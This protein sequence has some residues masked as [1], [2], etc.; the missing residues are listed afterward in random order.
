MLRRRSLERKLFLWLGILSVLP[1]LAVLLV[2]F[3]VGARSLRLIGTLGPWSRVA[4]S[5]RALIEQAE[6]APAADSTLLAAAARHRENLSESLMQA[7]RWEFLGERLAASAPLIA[8]TLAVVLVVMALVIS[9]GL[10]HQLARPI[11]ELV[12]WAGLLGRGEAIPG[13]AE[14]ERRELAD[15]QVL[16]N[17][18]RNAANEIEAGR[19]R[20]LEAERTRAWG[21]I[22]R[23]VAH[24]MKNPL[25]PLRLAAHQL[26]RAAATDAALHETAEVIRA[27]TDRLDEL[28]KGFA[29]LGR[30]TPGPAAE[31]DL[32]ELLDGLLET[33]VPATIRHTIDV[34]PGTSRVLG[35]YDALRRAFRNLIRNAVEAIGEA[36]GSG[37]GAIDI[38]VRPVDGTVEIVIADTGTGIPDGLAEAIFEPD[39]SFKANGTGLGL[40]IVRQVTAA[41]GGSVV[42]RNRAP[43][44][45]EFVIRLP[46]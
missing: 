15:V 34:E 29:M 43:H 28:A 10:A 46:A 6:S 32:A 33:D 40:A 16:R 42:A 12:E 22:A 36:N 11:A 38:R 27:E 30:P 18:I 13:P 9:R 20:S 37:S 45:A 44:G 24:E 26:E 19:R 31:V 25:T 39:Q 17:A 1:A 14:S 41:H 21:E 3:S 35:H 4:E 23:R 8:A 5:G 2:S 7:A